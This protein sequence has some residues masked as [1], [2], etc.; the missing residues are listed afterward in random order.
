MWVVVSNCKR[1]QVLSRGRGPSSAPR[2]AIVLAL[3]TWGLQLICSS[4][5]RCGE[6]AVSGR[7]VERVFRSPIAGVG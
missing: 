5:D 7:R 2:A 3:A 6:H 4:L 1:G